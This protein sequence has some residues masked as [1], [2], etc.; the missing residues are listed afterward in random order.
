MSVKPE[1]GKLPD[2]YFSL[3]PTLIEP[4][5]FANPPILALKHDGSLTYGAQIGLS[6]EMTHNTVLDH[7]IA[8]LSNK[9]IVF[10]LDR[11]TKPG[12]GTKY[13]DVLTIYWWYGPHDE[14]FGFRFGVVNYKTKP[15]VLIEPI[16]WENESW[17][18]M[19]LKEIEQQYAQ[20]SEKLR[21]F[22]ERP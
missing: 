6:P 5:G 2:Y 9:E 12:Q 22:L 15:D 10:A 20:M 18:G 16:D 7:F 13:N 14:N 19:M 3:L 11:F 1:D 4:E 17:N 21:G 8:D